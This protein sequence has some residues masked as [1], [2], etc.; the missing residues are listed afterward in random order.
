ML[1]EKVGDKEF[2]L[3]HL[4]RRVRGG[5]ILVCMPATGK[6]IPSRLIKAGFHRGV[7]CECLWDWSV[8]ACGWVCLVGLPTR[9]MVKDRV[10]LTKGELVHFYPADAYLRWR[11]RVVR[12][13]HTLLVAELN[14]FR[15]R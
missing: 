11:E 12:A 3:G 6:R 5:S 15:C 2:R 9:A 13:R 1:V 14:Y 8:E 10:E 7:H 4:T